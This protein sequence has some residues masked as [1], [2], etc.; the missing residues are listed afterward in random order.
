MYGS[1]ISFFIMN[2][3]LNLQLNAYSAPSD[4]SM[5]MI[6]LHFEEVAIFLIFCTTD[7]QAHVSGYESKVEEL[8]IYKSY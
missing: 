3:K 6:T 5:D 8:T 4:L 1:H 7:K 2:L